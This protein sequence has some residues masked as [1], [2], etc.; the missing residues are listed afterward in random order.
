M[1]TPCFPWLRLRGL[2]QCTHAAQKMGEMIELLKPILQLVFGTSGFATC[3]LLALIGS[4]KLLRK[5]K[6]AYYT[7]VLQANFTSAAQSLFVVD[8]FYGPER[9]AA[10]FLRT[11][12]WMTVL[13]LAGAVFQYV[14]WVDG[15]WASLR[16][17]TFAWQVFRRQILT[18]G[19]PIVLIVNLASGMVYATLRQVSGGRAGGLHFLL[20]DTVTRFV[21]FAVMMLVTYAGSAALFGSFGGDTRVAMEAVLPTLAGAL[22][23]ENLTAAYLLAAFLGGVPIFASAALYLAEKWPGF[24]ASLRTLLDHLPLSDKPVLM[25]GIT[26]SALVYLAFQLGSYV[27]SPWV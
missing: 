8:Q 9:P 5:E 13:G 18:T 20:F 11:T 14:L 24:G 22:R 27:L 19:L 7:E 17:D 2:A 21:I 3:V 12:I 6:S 25:T 15:F 10:A 16:S 26:F 4:D 23:F 1:A